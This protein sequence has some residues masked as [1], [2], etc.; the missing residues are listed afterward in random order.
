MSRIGSRIIKVPETVTVTNNN[1]IIEV[2]GPKGTLTQKLAKNIELKQ[3]GNEITLTAK[4]EEANA[5][6]GTRNALI[7]NMI[8]G[9]TSGFEKKLQITGVGYRFNAQGSK[10][11]ISAGYSH[12]VEM[13]VPAGLTIEVKDNTELS[14]RGIS[15]EEVGE[16]AANVRKVR[17][18]EPY[19]GK[20]IRY[21]DEHIIRKEGKKAA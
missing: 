9:V 15:K 21:K 11:V 20:G 5:M 1:G 16:F 10:L 14:V 6:H 4:N 12:P 18:P 13:Q 8:T 2:K 19:K 17:Q 7:T 3:E